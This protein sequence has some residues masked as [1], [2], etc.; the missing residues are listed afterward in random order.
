[1]VFNNSVEIKWYRR[2][3]F[4]WRIFSFFLV[5]SLLY[6]VFN[7]PKTNISSK[8]HIANYTISGLLVDADQI[9][10]DLEYLEFEDDVKAIIITVDSPGGTTVSAEEIFL[11]IRSISSNKPIVAVMK[12][13]A[14]SGAY[15]FSIGADRIFARENTITGSVGVL[16][17]WARID[18]G[19]EKLGI[20]MKEVKSGKLKAEPDLFGESDEE[21][22]ALTQKIVDETFTWFLDLVKERRNVEDSAIS[23]MSDGRIF[24]GRQALELNLIDE[25]GGNREAKFWLIE[26]REINTDLEILIYDQNKSANFIELS[27]AK[28]MD[29]FNINSSYGDSLKNNLSLINIDGLLSTWQHPS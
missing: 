5:L 9:L 16:L 28:I 23:Q 13:I 22:M 24:T 19:L 17:Q 7:N 8:P 12:N 11:K 20:E 29:Y 21:A 3:L 4:L 14:T 27:V 10:E 2:K 26:N 15:L 25:I 18:Q 1:M 6:I